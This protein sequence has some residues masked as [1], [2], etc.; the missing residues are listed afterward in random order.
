MS[1]DQPNAAVAGSEASCFDT[2]CAAVLKRIIAATLTIYVQLSFL[3]YESNCPCLDTE[4]LLST[5]FD[6]SLLSTLK[7]PETAALFLTGVGPINNHKNLFKID[8]LD[9]RPRSRNDLFI[10]YRR[11]LKP[12]A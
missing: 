9:S 4:W 1:L 2:L 6:A 12:G 8:S 11:F 7:P 5:L 10:I 3:A